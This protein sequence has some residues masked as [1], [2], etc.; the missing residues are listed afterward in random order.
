MTNN[1]KSDC[2]VIIHGAS[3]SAALVGGGMA[4]LP[5]S[6]TVALIPI[7]IAMVVALGEVFDIELTDSAAKGIVL[8]TGAGYIGRAA[9]QILVGWIPGIGN[10]INSSTAVGLTEFIGWAVVKK[11]D[12]N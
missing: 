2:Q 11:F 6:D 4:Q 3:G 7:Q 8:G 1:Q 10:L 9:S 12:K 5:C